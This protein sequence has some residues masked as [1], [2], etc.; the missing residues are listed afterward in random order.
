MD[1]IC[2]R[3]GEPTD[4]DSFH[5]EVSERAL[6]GQETTYREVM[7]EFQTKGCGVA[8][9]SLYGGDACERSDSLRAHAA[10]ALGDVL[11]DDTDGLASMMEDF[12][13]LGVFA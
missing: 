10:A 11:G 12:D 13:A 3:C 6:E 2:P 4:N 1:H 9:R 7:R 5:E 8:L